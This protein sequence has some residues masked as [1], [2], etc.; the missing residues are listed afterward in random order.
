MRQC[1][2]VT[3]LPPKCHSNDSA[4]HSK[5]NERGKKQMAQTKQPLLTVMSAALSVIFIIN[6]NLSR[7]MA[8]AP[9]TTVLVAAIRQITLS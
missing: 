2:S 8:A 6:D 4:V 7:G 3:K 1:Q 5:H 9:I